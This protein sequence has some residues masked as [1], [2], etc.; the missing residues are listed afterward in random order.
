MASLLARTRSWLD[1]REGSPTTRAVLLVTIIL[2]VVFGAGA[3]ASFLAWQDPWGPHHPDEG[4]LPLEAVALWEG[5]TPREVG[6][7]ASTTR[8]MLS[9][10]AATE[11]VGAEGRAT[12]QRRAEPQGVLQGLSSWIADRY[13]HQAPGIRLGRILSLLTACLH[14][15]VAGWAG[16]RWLGSTGAPFAWLSA[17]MCPVAV[18]YSQYVLSDV[19][20]VLFATAVVALAAVPTARG[21]LVMAGMVGL[22]T[23]SKFHF[24]LWLLTP[25]L[26]IWLR[27][28]LRAA[29]RLK[30]TLAV[31]GLF[32][33]VVL[34]FV[35]WFWINPLLALKEFAGVVLVKIGNAKTTGGLSTNIAV[36]VSALGSVIAAGTA[37][38]VAPVAGSWRQYAPVLLPTVIG[39]VALSASAIVFDR[40]AL[41][42]L[43][44]LALVAARGWQWATETGSRHAQTIVTCALALTVATT[45]WQIVRATGRMAPIDVDVLATRW[46]TEHVPRGA[47]VAVQE[48]TVAPL[49]REAQQ[50]RQC[51][52]RVDSPAGY[53]DKWRLEGVELPA[54]DSLPMQGVVMNDERVFAY[55]CRQ[56]LDASKDDGFHVVPYHRD[57]HFWSV[58]E[59][60]AIDEF[61]KGASDVTGGID[62]LVLNRVEDVGRPPARVFENARGRRVIYLRTGFEAR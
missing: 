41:V 48:E 6:W 35:P 22:A 15:L 11:W 46:I 34:T 32:A 62:V 28:P 20:G 36:L 33:W 44:G 39:A 40:Y 26:C 43:P 51:V 3:R 38:A 25:L 50:L 31:L 17:A 4:I 49:P 29:A 10:G 1:A 12:W 59:R 30:L 8:L 47:R 53:R 9:A 7:P 2:A 37:L 58:R 5:V 13:V 52:E 61:A 21:M 45:G 23:A 55:W 42:L 18:A 19:Q 54:G 24:G 16:R 14:L 27:L 56:E 60:Q 57:A